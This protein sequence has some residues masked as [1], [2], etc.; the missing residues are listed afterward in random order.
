MLEQDPR[1]WPNNQPA[2]GQCTCVHMLSWAEILAN[3]VS[4]SSMLIY[5]WPCTADVGPVLNQHADVPQLR[6]CTVIVLN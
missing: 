6:T 4:L 5:C 3:I 2:L 1:Q